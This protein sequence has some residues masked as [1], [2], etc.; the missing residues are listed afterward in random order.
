MVAEINRLH[1]CRLTIVSLI[2]V[3]PAHQQAQ[4]NSDDHAGDTDNEIDSYQQ[5]NS[6]G[7]SAG[8]VD[9]PY[10]NSDCPVGHSTAYCL[11]WSSGY[12]TGFNAQKTIDESN[13]QNDNVNSDN[14]D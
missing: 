2:L 4:A 12:E 13:G 9:Y 7:E 5:G 3:F 8:L 11:G 1:L 14:D 6:D 10:R